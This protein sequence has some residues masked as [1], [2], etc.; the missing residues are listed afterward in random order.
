MNITRLYS[1]E[2]GESRLDS[3]EL[4][5]ELRDFAPP[6]APARISEA[7][8]ASGYMVIEL[9]VGWGGETPH[10]TPDR[11]MLFCLSG[12]VC[13]TTSTGDTCTIA[14]GDALLMTDTTGKGHSTS[15]I[16]QEPV[17]A[18]MIRL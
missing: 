8:E 6:A 17:R 13:I 3:W 12:S 1:D 18:V 7:Q 4:E 9:P 16:S 15:V 14:S 11:Y 10:P 5:Q 2:S